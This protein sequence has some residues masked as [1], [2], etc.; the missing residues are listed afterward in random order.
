VDVEGNVANFNETEQLVWFKNN[1]LASFVQIRGSIPMYWRQIINLKYKPQLE[2]DDQTK[3]VQAAATHFSELTKIYGSKEVVVVN[4]IDTKGYEL[5]VGLAFKQVM[6]ALGNQQKYKYVH[7]DFHTQCKKMRYD[8]LQKLMDEIKGS[9]DQLTPFQIDAYGNAVARQSS[10]IRTNCM[11]C[12]DRT[13]VV[14]A[15][16]ARHFLRQQLVQQ[17]IIEEN[18]RIE[19]HRELE[20]MLRNSTSFLRFILFFIF[21]LFYTL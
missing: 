11:D 1:A 6:Q 7:F 20:T 4:L 19:N 16:F 3:S 18:D 12:L 5:K 2:I 15:L 9:L 14:Q 17:G 21:Y 13:N 10:V 8:N